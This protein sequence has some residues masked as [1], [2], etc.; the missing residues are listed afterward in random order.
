[1]GKLGEHYALGVYLGS[2]RLASYLHIQS[3]AVEPPDMS[4]LF[5]QKCLM[6]S[7]EDRKLLEQPDRTLIKELG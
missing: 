1:M 2:E 5:I 7:Y 3:G 6:A 4:V